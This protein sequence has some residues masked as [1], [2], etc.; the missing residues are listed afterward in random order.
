MEG[1]SPTPGYVDE[2]ANSH[3]SWLTCLKAYVELMA[4]ADILGFLSFSGFAVLCRA[5]PASH[6]AT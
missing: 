6:E 2:E 5:S 3:K 1:A 4:S